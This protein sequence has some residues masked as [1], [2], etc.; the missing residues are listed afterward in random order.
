MKMTTILVVSDSH[1]NKAAIDKL[2]PL[3]Q[4]NDYVIHLG[5][6]ANDMIELYRDF[7]EKV[8]VCNGNCDGFGSRIALNEWEIEVGKYKLFCCHGHSYRV[9][10][11]LAELALEAKKRGCDV[12]LYGHTHEA[13][14]DELFGVTLINPG[15]LNRYSKGSYCYLVL[16]ENKIIP[17]IV[18]L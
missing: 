16:T 12:A 9:K 7:P 17:T 14:I 13:R 2:R 18:E 1:G 10:S 15:T 5:D 11:T 8:Y 3:V 4:E 6:G